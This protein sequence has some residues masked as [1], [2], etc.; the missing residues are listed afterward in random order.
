MVPG[1]HTTDLGAALEYLNNVMKKKA[2]CFVLSDYQTDD[3]EKPL[4][5]FAR[6]HDVTGICLYDSLEKDLPDLGLIPI[7]DPET[8]KQSWIDASSPI[9]REIVQQ[10]FNRRLHTVE[11]L[12]LRSGAGFI[13][14]A[15]GEDY[16]KSLMRYFERRKRR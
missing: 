15:T 6:R 12:F 1:N 4:R 10:R 9:L 8:G 3:Y 11:E 2:V 14:V 5:V 7:E 16:V 13:S